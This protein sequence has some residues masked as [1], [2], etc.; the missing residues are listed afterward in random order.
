MNV[1]S[2]KKMAAIVHITGLLGD[3]WLCMERVLL[4]LRH[5]QSGKCCLVSFMCAAQHAASLTPA[6][7]YCSEVLSEKVIRWHFAVDVV[8]K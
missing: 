4:L 6:S 8:H 5:L 1:S 7:L 2:S 3:R